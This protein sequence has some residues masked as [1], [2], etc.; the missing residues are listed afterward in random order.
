MCR[1]LC[2]LALLLLAASG[3]GKSGPVDAEAK[4]ATEWILSKGGTI[5][6]FDSDLP[7][8]RGATVP[9]RKFGVRRVDLNEKGVTDA[10]LDKLKDLAN[11]EYLGL[12]SARI[13][14]AGLDKIAAMKSLR[15][16]ELSYTRINDEGLK[17]LEALPNLKKIFLYGTKVT[18]DGA[19]SFAKS[20]SGCE[21]L[22]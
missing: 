19:A 7:L 15:E 18:K 3:C 9:D 1:R 13:S 4:T 21:V 14:N 20:K 5:Y 12:H 11:V 16:V 8:K 17:K 6:V 10:D 22:R 2:V